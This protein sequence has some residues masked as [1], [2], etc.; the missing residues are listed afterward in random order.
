M[1]SQ[2]RHARRRTA[3]SGN[4]AAHPPRQRSA[5]VT[6][7]LR[8][9]TAALRGVAAVVVVAAT[10]G[11]ASAGP[12]Y[13]GPAV[14]PNAQQWWLTDTWH[15]DRDVWP[16]SQG[17]GVT[18]AVIDTGVGG[19]HYLPPEMEGD[20]ILPGTNLNDGQSG[21]FDDNGHGT[22]M[23]ELI[24]ARGTGGGFAGLAPKSTILPVAVISGTQVSAGIRWSVDH[25]A[26]V[27]SISLG[28]LAID[29]EC[30]PDMQ[31]AVDYAVEHDVIIVASAGNSGNGDNDTEAPGACPGVTAVGAVD[32]SGQP[33]EK[34]Q[35]KPYVAVAA[36]GVDL[37]V[38]NNFDELQRTSGTSD[39]TALV[40]ATM[41]LVRAKYPKL[42]AREVV[43]RVV[44]TARDSGPK[45]RDDTT[46]YGIVDPARALTQTV[47]P[48]TANPAYDRYD[49]MKADARHAVER[50]H[51][52]SLLLKLGGAA[53]VG[54]VVLGLAMLVLWSVRRDRRAKRMRSA[55][56]GVPPAWPAAQPGTFPPPQYPAAP[57]PG[58]PPP[59]YPAAPSWHNPNQEH[60]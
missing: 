16:L 9:V 6:A 25:N 20:F 60:R 36:P 28:G 46:G 32:R 49:A 53:C 18:V 55:G 7:A 58:A 3:G 21:N 50:R 56:G 10:T 5:I 11:L 27:I 14:K 43:Q 54:L 52:N 37:P 42:S 33:W 15:V 57:L 59:Q 48:G 2:Y 51:R 34:T 38:K 29:D 19:G 44:G 31:G 22:E 23:A 40:S 8:G 13:A 39:S 12:A 24:A 45:G 35:R 1:R 41:A 47:P 30:S 4:S 26:K 17:Q